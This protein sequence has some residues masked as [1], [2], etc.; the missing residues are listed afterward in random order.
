MSEPINTTSSTI[1]IVL[2]VFFFCIFYLL[3][4]HYSSVERL[5]ERLGVFSLRTILST[6]VYRC[7]LFSTGFAVSFAVK[8]IEI[9]G[10]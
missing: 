7:S 3:T 4:G 5:V 10:M 8:W 6:D 1:S 9:F 2:K